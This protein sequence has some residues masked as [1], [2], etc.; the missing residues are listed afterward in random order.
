ML[1]FL[2]VSGIGSTKHWRCCI[3]TLSPF[4]SSWI[5][6]S[7][8]Y[9]FDKLRS[10]SGCRVHVG[11]L[12]DARV[13]TVF[14]QGTARLM[15]WSPDNLVLHDDQVLWKTANSFIPAAIGIDIVSFCTAGW[16]CSSRICLI[17]MVYP[18]S[19]FHTIS[20]IPFSRAQSSCRFLIRIFPKREGVLPFFE[21]Q[22]KSIGRLRS[23]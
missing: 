11:I 13:S 12:A 2:F 18:L 22:W 1:L 8:R 16:N 15:Y 23:G 6:I 5:F 20:L 7:A 14:W 4:R 19:S 3:Y 9:V 10:S 17:A 21:L